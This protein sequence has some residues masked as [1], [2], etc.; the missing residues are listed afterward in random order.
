MEI[1]IEDPQDFEEEQVII[2]CRQMTPALQHMIAL[3]KTQDGLIAYDK[4]EIHRI[5][6]AEIYYIEVVDNKTFL[7]CNDKLYESKQNQ[8]T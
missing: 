7:Y 4:N 3:L 8:V 5:Q 6:L 2:K 1:I